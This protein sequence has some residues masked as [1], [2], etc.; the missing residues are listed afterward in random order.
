MASGFS[1]PIGLSVDG[2]GGVLVAALTDYAL[3]SVNSSGIKS[4]LYPSPGWGPFSVCLDG[5]GTGV[6]ATYGFQNAVYHINHMTSAAVI[7]AG[8]PFT[9][10]S[11]GDGVSR[12]LFARMSR[13]FYLT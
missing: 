9:A 1:F 2:M 11:S 3:F 12:W 6:Y 10:G 5:L 8:I 13:P 4:V 7:V